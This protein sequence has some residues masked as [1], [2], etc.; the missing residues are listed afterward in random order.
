MQTQ[1]ELDTA[2]PVLKQVYEQDKSISNITQQQV[3]QNQQTQ[4]LAIREKSITSRWE[5]QKAILKLKRQSRIMLGLYQLAIWI[6]LI[7]NGIWNAINHERFFVNINLIP[8]YFVLSAVFCFVGWMLQRQSK[9]TILQINDIQLIGP[10]AEALDAERMVKPKVIIMALK[11]L[12]PRLQASDAAVLTRNQRLCL[13]RALSWRGNKEGVRVLR[14][15]R[16]LAL[17]ILKAMEQIG[18]KDA[19]PYVQHVAK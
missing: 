3:V 14:Y 15:D 1:Q 9:Q 5:A 4:E 17:A 16:D 18:D 12:L 11:R 2:A 19:L 8:I 6:P 10:L 7:I 13:Y